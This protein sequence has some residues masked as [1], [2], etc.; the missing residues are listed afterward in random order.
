MLLSDRSSETLLVLTRDSRLVVLSNIP[1]L[2]EAAEASSLQ[3]CSEIHTRVF[4]LTSSFTEVTGLL[5]IGKVESNKLHLILCGTGDVCLGVWEL[6]LVC[7]EFQRIA[8]KKSRGKKVL[9]V[10]NYRRRQSSSTV[11]KI[12]D[13]DGSRMLLV[14][15]ADMT[16]ELWDAFSLLL[17]KKWEETVSAVKPIRNGLNGKICLVSGSDGSLKIEEVGV[18]KGS[19]PLFSFPTTTSDSTIVATPEIYTGAEF[20]VFGV[21]P[22]TETLYGFRCT[23]KDDRARL[24]LLIQHG[25][26]HLAI[27]IARENKLGKDSEAYV[28]KSQL[29]FLLSAGKTSE[30]LSKKT[31]DD[32]KEAISNLIAS[33]EKVIQCL[34]FVVKGCLNLKLPYQDDYVN[35][36]R[37]ARDRCSSSMRQDVD[38]DPSNAKLLSELIAEVDEALLHLDTYQLLKSDPTNAFDPSSWQDFRKSPIQVEIAKQFRCG[39]MDKVAIIWERHFVSLNPTKRRIRA[40]DMIPLLDLVPLDVDV[41]S[42]CSWVKECLRWELSSPE[43]ED[44]ALW[45]TKK[46]REIEQHFKSPHL[47]KLVTESCIRDDAQDMFKSVNSGFNTPARFVKKFM[48][49]SSTSLEVSRRVNGPSK[50]EAELVRI[51]DHLNRLIYLQES[52]DFVFTLEEAEGMSTNQVICRMLD[53]VVAPELLSEEIEHHVKPFAEK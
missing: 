10:F 32:V 6:D 17:V 8:S 18:A 21:H 37:Y 24:K 15:Y 40:V 48:S 53:R 36:L 51:D 49:R 41:D 47:A 52:H 3:I 12:S 1:R 4:D 39:S 30:K 29:L 34:G 46:A 2:P 26:F 19:N 35:L 42:Y 25:R 27:K 45:A 9:S 13:D 22:K 5:N 20:L 50:A 43:W 38:A 23:E 33:S 16:L 14:H 7:W 28:Y 44:L 31:F 11:G